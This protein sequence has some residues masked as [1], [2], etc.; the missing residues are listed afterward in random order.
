MTVCTGANRD[1]LL[2][3]SERLTEQGSR[4]IEDFEISWEEEEQRNE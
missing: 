1:D 2:E 4:E 3:R